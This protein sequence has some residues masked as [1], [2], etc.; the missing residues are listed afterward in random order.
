MGALGDLQHLVLLAILR[1][2]GQA[3]GVSVRDEI[4]R[5]AGRTLS[6]GAVYSALRRLEAQGLIASRRGEPEPVT[7]GRAKT[8]FTVSSDGLAALRE[9]QRELGRMLEGLEGLPLSPGLPETDR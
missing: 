9:A 4:E 8:F 6:L 3:Y 7:G 1:L 5:T 2:E